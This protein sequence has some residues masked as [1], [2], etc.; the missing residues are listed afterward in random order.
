MLVNDTLEE[1][2]L[3]LP[4]YSLTVRLGAGGYGE[5]WQAHAPGG[6]TKA[7][8]FIYGS[9]H[10]KRAENELRALQRIKEVRHPFIL[11]LERIEVVNGRLAI[12]TELAESSLKDRFD[13]CLRDGLRGIA[14]AE[15]LNYLQDAAD[16]LDFL[17]EKHG[18]QHLDV[19]P[20]NLLL[21]AGHVKVADFGLVKDVGNS[22]ASLVGGL[23]PLYSAP[24]VFQGSPSTRSDQYSLAVLYQ[25]MF[26]GALP[27]SGATAAELTLQHLHDEPDFSSL[28]TADRYVLA[29]ALA[30]DPAQRYS[31]CGEMVAALRSAG[32]GGDW[33]AEGA[34]ATAGDDG[35]FE[36]I[37]PER[38]ATPRQ[39]PVT[40]FFDER[41]NDRR[42]EV[43]P[44]MLLDWEPPVGGEPR[45]LPPA[46]VSSDSFESQPT[47][48]LGIGGVAASVLGQFRLQL[49]K[50][51]GEERLPAV[52]LLLLDSDSKSIAR[53]IQGEGRQALRP[54]ETLALPLRRPQEYREQSGK[55]MRWLSRRW[56]YNIPKSLQTEGLRPLGRL[57]LADHARQAVQRIRMSLAE[58]TDEQSVRQSAEQSGVA[59]NTRKPRVYVVASISGGSGSGM[60]LD[61]GYAARTALEK[62]GFQDGQIVGI[63]LNATSNDPRQC[64]LSRVN[65]YAWLT[66]Y[67]HWH[68]PGG[69]FC[70]DESFGLPARGPDQKAF[71]SAYLLN[72]S[73][74]EEF[75]DLESV[76]QSVA[77][78]IF[79]DALTPAQAFFDH[80]R[81]ETPA[82]P[83]SFGPLRTFRLNRVSASTDAAIES[84]AVALSRAVAF[85]WVGGQDV[86][87][88]TG[89]SC[90]SA[91][92]ANASS[93]RDT[94]QLVEGAAKLV[95]RLQLQ[96][97]GLASNARA[98][99]ESQYGGDPQIFIENLIEL[100]R[101]DGNA[102]TPDEMLRV[103]DCLFKAPNDEGPGPHI[104]QRPLEVIVSPLSMKLASDLARWVLSKLDDRQA[105]LSG[106]ERAA[107]WLIEH[108]SRVASD[109][110]RLGGGLRKQIAAIAEEIRSPGR[111]EDDWQR[112][113]AYFR[114]RTDEHAVTASSLVAKRLLAELKSVLETIIEFGRHLKN[115][116]AGMPQSDLYE[117]A[118]PLST[119]VAA[120]FASLLDSVDQ[121]V[122]ESFIRPNGGLFQTVM[123]NSRLRAQMLQELTRHARLVVDGLAAQPELIGAAVTTADSRA[124]SQ[125]L[126]TAAEFAP[127][128]RH[129]GVCR[130]LVVVP[131]SQ[132]DGVQRVAGEGWSNFTVLTGA[133]H[134]VVV[135]QEGWGIPLANI[136]VDIIQ[137]RRDYAD[138][139]S[140]VVS[141]ND[142]RWTQL[143]AP[144]VRF[145][146]AAANAFSHSTPMVTQV[147]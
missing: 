60:S 122:Q 65:A 102:A 69:E 24:E 46:A 34:S 94:N 110:D 79:L 7:V 109:A 38:R 62:A 43:S 132:A 98:L 104:L 137:R 16:A 90:Q 3:S 32:A 54:E 70:G 28:P 52:Q 88:A 22:Q 29:R 15:L 135:C 142:V 31:S 80:C 76:A 145:P 143:G 51:F 71:D 6:L 10:D 64:D 42:K 118:D 136:A 30:K 35:G 119:L 127:L 41:L 100:T 25:E 63:F 55:L 146:Q 107:H 101:Q 66:E 67:N 123:G 19:K 89:A 74:E 96:L 9:F 130:N 20:E 117:A 45:S 115:I 97:E 23:T 53:A 121:S 133:G 112:A 77:Q 106:A 57:A 59:F 26:S 72:V 126:G 73:A 95:G 12:V 93:V 33:G 17:S 81:R 138:F 134:D 8:K 103:V 111:R 92:R 120:S 139:A 141:R 140:R 87:P 99:I 11:S 82:A 124:G 48:V 131:S 113:I 128:L 27:F 50:Q 75:A 86:P 14:R 83:A 114:M 21:V 129:G 58:A 13:Q 18:L 39:G 125:A 144:T 78:Y 91:E 68:R 2:E 61:V 4:G 49:S 84:A 40:E 37:L 44:S 116:A 1:R 47:L 147:L 105:R 56:L 5:V 108:L 85:R 36:P